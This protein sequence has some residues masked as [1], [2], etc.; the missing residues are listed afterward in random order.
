VALLLPPTLTRVGGGRWMVKD[1]KTSRLDPPNLLRSLQMEFQFV[2]ATPVVNQ[3][4]KEASA[5][6]SSGEVST[7]RREERRASEVHVSA[8]SRRVEV[9]AQHISATS[10]SGT[11]LSG[12]ARPSSRCHYG[13]H[14]TSCRS[15]LTPPFF[16]QL[17]VPLRGAPHQ[18]SVKTDPSILPSARGATTRGT[19][20]AVGQN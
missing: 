1:G 9:P 8:R 7:S 19:S 4:G 13:G 3:P 16:P 15:K 11:W 20:P 10:L 6:S 17:E 14:L 18:L 12:G 5:K 2:Y